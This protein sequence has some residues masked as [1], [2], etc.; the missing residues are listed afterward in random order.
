M[1]AAPAALATAVTLAAADPPPAPTKNQCLDAYEAG[2]RLRKASQLRAAR[3]QF[4]ICG[5]AACPDFAKQDCTKWLGE[6]DASMPTVVLIARDANGAAIEAVHVTIDGHPLTERADGRPIA[7]DPGPHDVR[8][9]AGGKVLDAHVVVAEGVHDQQLVA[10]FSK[11]APTALPA[12]APAPSPAPP[13]PPP[14]PAPPTGKTLPT[15]AWVLG[16]VAVV[17][18]ASFVTFAVLGRST[19]SCAPDCTS[20]Q[21]STLRRDY[22]VADISWIVGLAAA[23]GALYFVLRPA[24]SAAP[25][26][27]WGLTLRPTRGGAGVGMEGSF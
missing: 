2:Q 13:P 1:L 5:N 7:V 19:Q 27:A 15:A 8:Y 11:A 24:P 9:E 4:A 14:P 25:A 17:G 12:P 18:A 26:A 20:S 23:G 10:D 16:G 21:V 22:L 3:D 6:V